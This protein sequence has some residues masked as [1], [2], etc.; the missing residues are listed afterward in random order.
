MK[1]K[2]KLLKN[3]GLFLLF[4]NPIIFFSQETNE[5]IDKLKT[6]SVQDYSSYSEKAIYDYYKLKSNKT[7]LITRVNILLK[8]NRIDENKY[9][10]YN[11]RIENEEDILLKNYSE[12][13]KK[14]IYKMKEFC[15]T[16]I[17]S[18][19]NTPH[20]KK[21]EYINTKIIENFAYNSELDINVN[22]II[23]KGPPESKPNNGKDYPVW[24]IEDYKNFVDTESKNCPNLLIREKDL[25]QYNFEKSINRIKSD[26]YKK[27]LS[28]IPVDENEYKQALKKAEEDYAIV[29]KDFENFCEKQLE[30]NIIYRDEWVEFLTVFPI[31]D[32]V[33]NKIHS[34]K[35]L[36]D[37]SFKKDIFSF[38]ENEI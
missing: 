11:K 36:K 13:I 15:E 38:E 32:D 23:K 31:Y 4:I 7:R 21:I 10:E 22:E 2:R 17:G 33:A 27:E 29:L 14:E 26:K 6:W 28:K 24:K 34:A 37:N 30:K 35:E 1:L 9:N 8:N 12:E 16:V 3:L 5:N 19:H 18:L 20:D 25:A